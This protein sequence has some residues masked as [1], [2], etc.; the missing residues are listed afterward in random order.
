LPAPRRSRTR[1]RRRLPSRPGPSAC[2]LDS[3]LPRSHSLTHRTP[4]SLPPGGFVCKMR[5]M[6]LPRSLTCNACK[7]TYPEGWLRCPFCGFD[8]QKQKR[9]RQIERALIKR[10]PSYAAAVGSEAPRK[11]Q[12]GRRDRGQQASQGNAAQNG[13]GSADGSRKRSRR[14]RGRKGRSADAS[15]TGSENNQAAPSQVSREPQANE[16][17]RPPRGAQRPNAGQQNASTESDG[18][19][20]RRRRRPRRRRSSQ[21]GPPD[22]PKSNG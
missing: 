8:P 10:F 1:D 13:Q 21:G 22:E 6:P 16:D 15:A 19:K 4:K 2:V 3:L 11:K 14:R 9:D 20:R 17:R 5:P 18:V 12:Q 7:R